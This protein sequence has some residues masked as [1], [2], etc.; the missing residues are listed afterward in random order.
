MTAVDVRPFVAD[1]AD[2]VV[3]LA[4]AAW[5]PVFDSFATVL[6]D[7]LFRRVYPDWK[8]YQAGSVRDALDKNDTWVALVDD[9]VAGFV[10]VIFDAAERSGEIYMIAVDPAAQRLGIAS[11]L[12][13]L[14]LDEMRARG[15]DLATVSTGGDP[16]H[17]PAR[18][19]Y[20]KAGFT[21]F[22]QVWYA[23]LLDS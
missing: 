11:R 10:N 3:D 23:K 19:T 14:A 18:H 22:P 8:T 7:D 1:D 20:E 2:R 5:T 15:L 21:A 17:A 4:L 16:G 12:T 13:Q 9:A 6:G